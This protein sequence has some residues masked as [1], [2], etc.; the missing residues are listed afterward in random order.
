MDKNYELEIYR[1]IKDVDLDGMSCVNEFGWVSDTEFCVWIHY[2]LFDEFWQNI[3][4]IFGYGFCDDGI[5]AVLL[6]DD[7]CIT[8]SDITDAYDVDLEKIFPKDKYRH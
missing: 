2:L 4:A 5:D 1:L 7:I 8:L 6:E 3:K